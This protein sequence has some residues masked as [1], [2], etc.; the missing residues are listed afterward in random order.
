MFNIFS[1]IYKRFVCKNLANYID[2]FLTKF[3]SAHRKS[4]CPNHDFRTILERWKKFLGRKRFVGAVLM[5]L[6][7]AFDSIPHDLTAKMHSYDLSKNSL[8][9]Y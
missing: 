3:F 7:K 1:K 2:T 6:S 8:L 5:D 9:S 4:Y